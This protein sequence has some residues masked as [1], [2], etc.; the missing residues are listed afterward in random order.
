MRNDDTLPAG[1][2]D[3]V[4]DRSLSAARTRATTRNRRRAAL[5]QPSSSRTVAR[6]LLPAFNSAATSFSSCGT[7]I[8]SSFGLSL[9]IHA[10]VGTAVGN[11]EKVGDRGNLVSKVIRINSLK[12]VAREPAL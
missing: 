1:C 12:P 3:D 8:S 9:V 5:N 10:I 11:R 7:A 6:G 2:S 4:E